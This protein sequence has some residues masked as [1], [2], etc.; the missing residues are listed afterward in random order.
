MSAYPITPNLVV[1][2]NEGA[3]F[4]YPFVLDDPKTGI[5]D[6]SVLASSTTG[7][8]VVDVSSQ[9]TK[10]S[11]SGGYNLLLGQFQAAQATFRIVDPNGDWNPMNT[12]S[13]YRSEEHTSELQSH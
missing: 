12:A 10:A 13:P 2:F 7:N 6:T 1:Y 8:L 5:L 4:G 3:T 9:C 11:L